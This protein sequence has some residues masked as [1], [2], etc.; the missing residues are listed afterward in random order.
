MLA[1][2]RR[3]L[4]RERRHTRFVFHDD[5]RVEGE[6]WYQEWR[7]ALDG[8]ITAQMA[9]DATKLGMARSG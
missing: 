8:V 5:Q 2:I 3:A 1:A 6:P 9:R 7:K 4:F